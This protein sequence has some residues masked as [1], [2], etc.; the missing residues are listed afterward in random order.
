MKRPGSFKIY[1]KVG[2]LQ[3]GLLLPKYNKDGYIEKEGAILFEMAPGAGDQIWDWK[4]KINFA[5]SYTDI[6]NFIDKKRIYHEHQE[7]PKALEIQVGEGKY[8]GT[9][10]LKLSAGT[11]EN[12]KGYVSVPLTN[13]EFQLLTR[14]LI[15]SVPL[16]IN[17]TTNVMES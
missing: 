11:K 12:P 3:A 17:W 1:K 14:L 15:D 7:T 4:N 8:Q 2:A 5:M 6:A 13:G 16:L 10:M 9:Y